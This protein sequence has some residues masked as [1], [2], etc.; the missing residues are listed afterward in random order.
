[1]GVG[2][3]CRTASL[4]RTLKHNELALLRINHKIHTSG[5]ASHDTSAADWRVSN[6][7]GFALKIRIRE[8]LNMRTY[9]PCATDLVYT[10]AATSNEFVRVRRE[11]SADISPNPRIRGPRRHAHAAERE[12]FVAAACKGHGNLYRQ[13]S[14]CYRV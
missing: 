10:Y 4:D 2:S 1:M 5:R 11:V 12:R 7:T 14:E 8:R 13:Q 9:S 6:G 3:A